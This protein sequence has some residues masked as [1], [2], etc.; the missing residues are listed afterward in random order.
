MRSS[1][2]M[3]SCRWC[4]PSR[5]ETTSLLLQ[6]QGC[7]H[8][9]RSHLIIGVMGCY[10]NNMR[11]YLW[12]ICWCYQSIS[13]PILWRILVKIFFSYHPQ[14]ELATY[15]KFIEKIV[16]VSKREIFTT[17]IKK[18]SKER[19]WNVKLFHVSL[20]LSHIS[21]CTIVLWYYLCNHGSSLRYSKFQRLIFMNTVL[22]F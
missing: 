13:L 5:A 7:V 3:R 18:Y 2:L 22:I 1:F 17:V 11:R 15:V 12:C 20:P 16:H 8:S 6:G 4:L 9:I 10:C 19:I 21:S 14:W